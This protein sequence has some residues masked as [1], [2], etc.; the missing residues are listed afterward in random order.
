MS[1]QTPSVGHIVHY[2]SLG[3]PVLADGAQ[4]YPST[5]RAAIVTATDPNPD[6]VPEEGQVFVGLAVLNPEGMYFNQTVLQDEVDH[7]PGSWHWPE[8]V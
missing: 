2:V 5:C 8:R 1:E 4:H 6:D 7:T 3:S